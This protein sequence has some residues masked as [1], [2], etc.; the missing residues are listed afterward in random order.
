MEGKLKHINNIW[1]VFYEIIEP[2][3]PTYLKEVQLLNQEQ[4]GLEDGK[5]VIFELTYEQ[6]YYLTETKAILTMTYKQAKQELY[7]RPW[8]AITCSQGERPW[9]AVTCSQGESCWCRII[10][11][12]EPIEYQVNK[13]EEDEI[14]FYLISEVVPMGAIDSEFAEYVVKLHNESLEKKS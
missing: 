11:T 5:K 14:R 3:Q 7:R 1:Y 4:E 2:Q 10:K 8:K 6:S 13:S 9:K 12:V